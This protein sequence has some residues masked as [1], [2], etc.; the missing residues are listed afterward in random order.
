MSDRALVESVADAVA[1]GEAVNWRVVERAAAKTRDA[2]PDP[3]T[4]DHRSHRGGAPHP[5]ATRSHVV[6]P[7]GGDWCG[8]RARHCRRAARAGDPGRSRRTCP[9]GVAS[10]YQRPRFSVVAAWSCW[11]AEGRDR[12]L[13]LLGGLFLTI[14]SAFVLWLMPPPGAA[15]EHAHRR[16]SAAAAGG[17]PGIDAVAFRSRVSR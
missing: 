9:G 6:E 1:A 5:H 17:V 10:H 11:P 7:Y 15:L 3:R 4:Q 12:R 8:R 2:R 13:A 14:S 16:S